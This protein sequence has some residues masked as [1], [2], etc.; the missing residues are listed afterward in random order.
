MNR[1][2]RRQAITVLALALVASVAAL[3]FADVVVYKNSFSSKAAVKDVK[4]VG[5]KKCK[6]KFVSKGKKRKFMRATRTTGPGACTLIPPVQGDDVRPAYTL[7]VVG[8][9]AKRTPKPA[10]KGGYLAAAVRVGSE[11]RYEL[12]VFPKGRRFEL[13]RS[14]NGERFP[15]RGRS[16]AIGGIG[17]KN[18]LSVSSTGTVIRAVVNGDEVARVSDPDSGDV[19][20]RRLHFAVGNTARTGKSTIAVFQK[21][22]VS[23]PDP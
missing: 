16:G 7:R 1:S 18:K 6:R 2:R 19:S 23:V 22:K 4:K 14:P 12:R 3:A 20:G 13:L 15:V 9:L 17:K 10:R 21:L 11:D 8:K 5:G